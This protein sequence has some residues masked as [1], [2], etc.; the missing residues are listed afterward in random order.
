MKRNSLI[1]IYI[2]QPLICGH[3]MMQFVNLSRH[4]LI[5]AYYHL[6]VEQLL[7]DLVERTLFYTVFYPG[8]SKTVV[9]RKFYNKHPTLH[10]NPKFLLK[11]WPIQVVNDQVMTVKE[12][13]TF[14]LSFGD[15][16]FE[17]IAYLSHF[18]T[19]LNLS[20]D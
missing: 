5:S 6:I 17:I 19:L 1:L 13:V 11:V 4:G 16:T 20:L 7:M 9:H 18:Q 12:T 3:K 14:L 8:A 2:Y 15:N 10:Q